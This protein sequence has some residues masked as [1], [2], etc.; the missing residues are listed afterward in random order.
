M[1][2]NWNEYRPS[3]AY[4]TVKNSSTS[5]KKEYLKRWISLDTETSH[6]HD[7][8]NPIG[9]VYQWAFK[10]GEE[11][12]YGR[13][14]SELVQVLRIIKE[15]YQLDKTK[16]CVVYVHNLSYDFSYLKDFII[17]AFG[18]FKILAIAKHHIITFTV[19]GFEFRC[20]YKLSN[21]SLAKWSSDLGCI[22]RKLEGFVDYEKIHYQTEGLTAKDWSYMFGDVEVLDECIERQL[23]LYGDTIATIPLTST[24]YIRRDCRAE[25]KKD[26]HNWRRFQRTRLTETTYKML[27]AEFS[28]GVT[29]GDR[30]RIGE[31]I[32]PKEGEWI[33]HRDFRSHYPSQQRTRGFPMGNFVLYAVDTDIATVNEQLKEHCV[34]C[35]VTIENCE[36]KDGNVTFPYLQVSKCIEGRVGEIRMVKDNGRV[37]QLAG[38]V[39]LCCNEHDL[40]WM[41]R[42]Y[43]FQTF[44]IDKLYVSKR[45]YLPPFMVDTIDKY[46]HGKTM[47]KILEKNESDPEK[48]LDYA[49]SL[50]KAKNGLN[51]IYGCS[52]TDCV[53]SSY[54][55]DQDA[56][57]PRERWKEEKPEDIGKALDKFYNSRNNFMRY[58]WGCWT[59]SGARDELFTFI[60]DVIGVER[61]LYCDTDSIF[62]LANEDT[63][64]RIKAYNDELTANSERIG[65][66]IEYEGKRV[67]YNYFDTEDNIASFRFLHSK[68]Y[69]YEDMEGQLHCTIAG[70]PAR[71][72]VGLDKDEKPIYY[73]R[74]EELGSIENLVENKQFTICGGTAVCYVEHCVD[75][76][77]NEIEV[78]EYASSAILMKTTKTL[79]SELEAHFEPMVY[80]W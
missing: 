33:G 20:S 73:T 3:T 32:R 70:V 62:Y 43:N 25:F 50:M 74:E 46:F 29:H 45:G 77:V 12:V 15:Y 64:K 61:C 13:K 47:Y 40:K 26:N 10:F 5:T 37:L 16:R 67:T 23:A 71:V 30:Y 51:G 52:A 79:S 38:K 60:Y 48:K 24:G 76:F 72:I 80:G 19:E 36:I 31:T 17:D 9:W 68:C 39:R 57:D 27:R 42:L 41:L 63:E 65:A 49:L 28:G 69:A 75:N 35:I 2:I 21:K 14:P 56:D 55:L 58:Q 59:T 78:T 53:R 1:Y 7:L 6:N 11:V 66:F 44:K 8:E 54:I 22:N 18:D 4:K 34:L